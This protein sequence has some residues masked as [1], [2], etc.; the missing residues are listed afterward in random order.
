[1]TEWYTVTPA[2]V[3]VTTTFTSSSPLTRTGVIFPVF[4]SDGQRNTT[5]SSDAASGVVA[6]ELAGDG[7]SQL[8]ATCAEFESFVPASEGT[9]DSLGTVASRNGYMS[10]L[11]QSSSLEYLSY[12]LRAKAGPCSA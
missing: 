5:F 8:G 2:L 4:S 3:N 6:V 9:W 12:Q 7:T 10:G 11:R 1:V